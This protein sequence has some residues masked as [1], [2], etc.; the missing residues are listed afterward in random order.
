MRWTETD[1]D[2]RELLDNYMLE[3]SRKAPDG[4]SK[5]VYKLQ[6]LQHGYVQGEML[7]GFVLMLL[8]NFGQL[9]KVVDEYNKIMEP[10][11]Q[12]LLQMPLF[13]G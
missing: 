4:N 2:V 12:D 6:N 5:K 7:E 8:D 10:H 3:F 1:S 13:I 9:E 11:K